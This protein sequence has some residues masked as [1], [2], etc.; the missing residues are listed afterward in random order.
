M[1]LLKVSPSTYYY[2]GKSGV[3]KQG[4]S[5]SNDGI[6]TAAPLSDEEV[7]REI[8]KYRKQFPTYGVPRMTA[9]LKHKSNM[10]VNH[11]RV[12]RIMKEN[13]LVLKRKRFKTKRTRARKAFATLDTKPF[14]EITVKEWDDVMPVNLKGI[15]LCSKAVYP[16][17][18]K[19]GKG[20][21]INISSGV[22]F[23]GLPLFLHYVT[24][25]GG[26]IGMT[27]A[28][29]REVGD[30]GICINAIAPGYT[31]TKVMEDDSIHDEAFINAVV[32]SRCFKRH[33]LPED[34]TGTIVFL[35]SDDSDFITGQ[36]IV[37][38]RGGTMH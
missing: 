25:K 38:D 31:V 35:A 14:Y 26:V 8:K 33:E 23:K 10:K 5:R 36:T 6:I 21:I 19:Q 4:V 12:Y 7:L 20:K 32:G 37:V 15:F 30:D 22:F 28:M 11:K 17:M 16:Q 3:R 18:K 27:R 1:N 2:K 24:S 13:H 9:L 29:A 34:L